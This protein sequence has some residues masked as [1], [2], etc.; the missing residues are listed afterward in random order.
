MEH[1][2]GILVKVAKVQFLPGADDLGV[3]LDVEPPHV[4]EEEP[5]H[6]IMW[7]S[8][9]FG[10]FVMNSMITSPVIDGSLVG[11]GVAEHEKESDGE[12]GGV[13]AV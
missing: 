4:C 2:D 9:G 3:F 10:I 5:A 11:D 8:V 12:G 13:G 7:V 1:D 6:G